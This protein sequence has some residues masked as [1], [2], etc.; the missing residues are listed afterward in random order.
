MSR[1]FLGAT[2]AVAMMT[3]SF[4]ADGATK[5]ACLQSGDSIGAFYVTK[6]AGAEEDG[7]EVGES[8][9][10]RCRYSSRPMVMVFTRKTDGEM[11]KLVKELNAAVKANDEKSLKGLVTLIGD[12]ADKLKEEGVKFAKTAGSDSVPVVVAKDT[13]TGPSSYKIS[14]SD[15]VTIVVANDSQ[16]VGTH[17]FKADS[18]DIAAVMKEVKEMLN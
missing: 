4:A 5:E 10:Y 13:K 16:V 6:V 7:V 11:P 15:D 2:L 9:C 14:E 12:D 1:L 8:L 17:T 18:I 3:S